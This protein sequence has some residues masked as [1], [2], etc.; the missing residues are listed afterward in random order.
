MIR[1]GI[2]GEIG[3]GKTFFAKLFKFPIF[4]ADRV[5]SRLYKE[6]INLF[7]IIKKK[8][9]KEVGS[10]PIKKE[11]LLKIIL[12]QPQNLK[13]LGRIIHPKVRKKMNDFLKVNK[14]KKFVVLDVPLLLENK[15]NTKRDIIIFIESDKKKIKQKIKKRKNINLKLISILKRNQIPLKLKKKKATFVIK[16]NFITKTA[17][18][19]V[20]LILKKIHK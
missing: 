18:K 13:A 1:I 9:P 17:K 12:N 3:S 16:N 2:V 20:K 4:D 11:E 8:F 14:K 5:V 7:S 10:F 15:L 19:N 6:D